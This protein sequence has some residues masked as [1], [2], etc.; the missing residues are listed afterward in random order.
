MVKTVV[1]SSDDEPLAISYRG[2]EAAMRR[3]EKRIRFLS[4]DA[5]SAINGRDPSYR[6]VR[7][8]IRESRE[9]EMR[10]A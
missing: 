4:A 8:S 7:F 3:I 10:S 2:R 6:S 9:M 1:I 5:L